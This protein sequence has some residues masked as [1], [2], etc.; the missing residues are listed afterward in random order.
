MAVSQEAQLMA[1]MTEATKKNTAATLAAALIAAS[2]RT[3]SVGEA[4]KLLR[5]IEWSLWPNPSY[6]AFNEWKKTFKP[7]EKHA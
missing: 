5:D 3:H 1:L 4:V 6:G 2:G 7:D